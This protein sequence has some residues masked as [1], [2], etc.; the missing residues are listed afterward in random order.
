[1]AEPIPYLIAWVDSPASVAFEPID[2]VVYFVDRVKVAP[3]YLE[4]AAYGPIPQPV[5]AL[6]S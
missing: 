1:V 4:S 6:E 3:I 2:P 5:E